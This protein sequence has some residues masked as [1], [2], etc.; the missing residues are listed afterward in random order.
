MTSSPV[1][2]AGEWIEQ[3]YAHTM[4][5]HRGVIDEG[6][7]VTLNSPTAIVGASIPPYDALFLF[8]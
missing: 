8:Q 4:T 5:M 6:G 2:V 7:T 1:I 3:K